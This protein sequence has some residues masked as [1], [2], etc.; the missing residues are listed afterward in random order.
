MKNRQP[1]RTNA[2]TQREQFR[3]QQVAAARRE[4]EKRMKEKGCYAPFSLQAIIESANPQKP[5]ARPPTEKLVRQLRKNARELLN[6][7]LAGQPDA[8][9]EFC[10]FAHNLTRQLAHLS[11]STPEQVRE[12]A[13]T[14]EEWPILYAPNDDPRAIYDKLQ[15][16][17]DSFVERYAG[18]KIDWSNP[19]TE[20]ALLVL[21]HLQWCK[22]R[23]PEITRNQPYGKILRWVLKV[24]RTKIGIN[25]YDT[26]S[27][28]FEVPEWCESCPRLADKLRPENVNQFWNVARLAILEYWARGELLESS[29]SSRSPYKVALDI[30]GIR[31]GHTDESSR[32]ADVLDAIKRAMVSLAGK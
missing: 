26:P 25:Y 28:A 24:G 1:A 29:S 5:S 19:W 7:S 8:M 17:S 30:K 2:S 31:K 4:L 13:S 6:R 9:K 21:G 10:R 12:I 27:G 22:R 32:R 3:E 11:E 15:V 20:R 14:Y 23:L 18:R 16:G